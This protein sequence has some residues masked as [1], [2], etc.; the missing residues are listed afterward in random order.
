MV[1]NSSRAGMVS[2]PRD[3]GSLKLVGNVRAGLAKPGV[4]ITTGDFL[5]TD[6]IVE[7]P[8]SPSWNVCPHRSGVCGPSSQGRHPS[9]DCALGV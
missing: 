3:G 4:L 7:K 9:G 5:H 8:L 2:T 1:Q 6:R